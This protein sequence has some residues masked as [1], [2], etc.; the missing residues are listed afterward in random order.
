MNGERLFV[1]VALPVPIRHSFD[2]RWPAFLEQY[3]ERGHRVVVPFQSRELVGIVTQV[4]TNTEFSE[5]RLKLVKRLLNPEFNIPKDIYALCEWA[6]HYYHAPFGEVLAQAL[7]PALKKTKENS[8][9]LPHSKKMISIPSSFEKILT[10][11]Q[12]TA[13]QE[14]LKATRDFKTFVL[15]GVTGSGKTEVYVRLISEMLMLD[16]QTLVLI[17]EIGL[18]PQLMAYFEICFPSLVGCMHSGLTPKQRFQ[19]WLSAKV[20][21]SKIILGTR[22][23]LFTPFTNLGLIIVDEEHDLSY[24]QQELFRYSARDMAVMRG[25]LENI[26]VVLGSATPSCETVRQVFR[27]QYTRLSL[28]VRINQ[29]PLPEIELIDMRE[30]QPKMG[31][32]KRVIEWTNYHLDQGE[33]ALF[34]LNRRGYAPVL[35]CHQCGWVVDCKNCDAH[36]VLHTLPNHQLRCHHCGNTFPMIQYCGGCGSDLLFPIGYGTVRAEQ[37]LETLFAAPVIR[38]DRDSTQKKGALQNLLKRITTHEPVLIIGTQ[39]LAKGHHFPNVTLVSVLDADRSLFSLDFRSTERLGQLLTQVAGRAGRGEKRGRVLLQTYH[40]EH[41]L[42]KQLVF[43]GYSA[44]IKTLLEERKAA[45]LPPFSRLALLQAEAR[46]AGKSL[47]F[48]QS[49]KKT[50]GQPNE[51][52]IW[53]PV[54]T[55]MEK[56]KGVFRAQMVFQALHR[57][58][59]HTYIEKTIKYLETLK[60]PPRWWLEIDPQEIY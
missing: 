20:G 19:A 26:P 29:S 30:E 24:K 6:S 25:Q 7:P 49:L 27:R 4:K 36:L 41:P 23:A 18:T 16:K 60:N 5:T 38:I 1:E 12:Q 48:L 58:P 55:S 21:T 32:S 11:D 54:P 56:K 13:I 31:L 33:Q 35:M 9:L 2:Y 34:L 57:A 15:E 8:I 45:G 28:P 47:T 52:T 3:P 51:I 22:S 53:G 39:M 17:P 37:N 10:Q 40:P 46:E 14:I 43:E 50:M 44:Y 59:L 42:L